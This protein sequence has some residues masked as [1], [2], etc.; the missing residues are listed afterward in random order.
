[1]IWQLEVDTALKQK[2]E[3]I[4]DCP[5]VFRNPNILLNKET[6]PTISIQLYDQKVNYQMKDHNSKTVV[7]HKLTATLKNK[8]DYYDFYYQI[9]FWAKKPRDINILT[10][11]WMSVVPPRSV[12]NVIDD[13]GNIYPLNMSFLHFNNLDTVKG[14][15]TIYRRCY[16]YKISVPLDTS[17]E[18]VRPLF[19]GFNL[20][21]NKQQKKF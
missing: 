15:D 17:V 18:E 12:I 7:K 14:E 4:V 3:S 11:K 2:L 5:V 6:Y 8:P 16:S 20:S 19:K 10:A 13:E 9:D 21:I 1:M